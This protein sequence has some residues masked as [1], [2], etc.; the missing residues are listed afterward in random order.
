M[1]AVNTVVISPDGQ[2]V[3]S[4]STDTTIKLWNLHTGELLDTLTGHS[5]A[6]VSLAINPDKQTLAS[7]STDGIIN[8]WNLRTGELLQTL[9]GCSPITFSS[10]GKTLVSGGKGGTIKIW[11]QMLGSDQLIPGSMLSEEWWEVLGVDKAASLKDVKGAYL[12]LARQYHPDINSSAS[13]KAMMQ[14]I[15][16]AYKKFRYQSVNN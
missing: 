16:G 13:A 12:R 9:S 15:N 14:A 7:S 8:L 6:V 10:N 2:T 1:K 11:R 4:G 5:A 3:I